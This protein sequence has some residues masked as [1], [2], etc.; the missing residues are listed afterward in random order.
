MLEQST[1][2]GP[3]WSVV[4]GM[5]GGLRLK[6]GLGNSAA[7]HS[8]VD[9]VPLWCVEVRSLGSWNTALLL[10]YSRSRVLG[11]PRPKGGGSCLK[12]TAHPRRTLAAELVRPGQ[13]RWEVRMVFA[14]PSG[15]VRR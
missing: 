7:G 1:L 9:R 3:V 2:G 4:G 12:P 11:I 6:P 15:K 5:W 13:Q 8:A 14:N 10:G